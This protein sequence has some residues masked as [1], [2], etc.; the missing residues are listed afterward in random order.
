MGYQ[1]RF[2]KR[3]ESNQQENFEKRPKKVVKQKKVKYKNY[4]ESDE[5]LFDSE[6]FGDSYNG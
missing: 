5:E 1:R 3:K 6:S 2:G 4:W